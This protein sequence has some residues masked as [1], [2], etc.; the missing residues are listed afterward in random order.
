MGDSESL[1][2]LK[3]CSENC[4]LRILICWFL[5]LYC[6]CVRVLLSQLVVRS[7]TTLHCL[8]TRMVSMY[9]VP[10]PWWSTRRKKGIKHT[11]PCADESFV[12]R[13]IKKPSFFVFRSRFSAIL[14]EIGVGQAPWRAVSSVVSIQRVCFIPRG[15]P[16]P[17]T[18]HRRRIPVLFSRASPPSFWKGGSLHGIC[19]FIG[20]AVSLYFVSG[21]RTEFCCYC[22]LPMSSE[23]FLRFKVTISHE[24]L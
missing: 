1:V 16:L 13:P 8:C 21:W 17:A 7:L 19:E 5:H 11:F 23:T 14:D 3:W 24:F 2:Y 22:G 18:L 4:R 15:D 10:P 20:E 6:R 12:L 9:W